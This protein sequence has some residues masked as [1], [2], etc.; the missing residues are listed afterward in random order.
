MSHNQIS[1]KFNLALH[2]L[3]ALPAMPEIAYRLLA[4]PLDT[5]AGEAQ[6]LS[7]IE[8]DPQ[9]SARI[10]GLANAPAMGSARRTS[11]IQDAA[12]LLGLQR[13]KSV[14]IGMA[15]LAQLA[16]QPATRNFDP[17]DLWSHSITVAIVMNLL[18]QAMPEQIRPDENQ[19]FLAGLL[20]DI[21]LMALHH[22]DYAACDELHHQVRLQP[23][24]S[25]YDIE[26]E[27]LGTTHGD[28]GAQ[29]LRHWHLPEELVGV[30]GRHHAAQGGDSANQLAKMVSLAERLLQDFG[31]AEHH[32]AAIS[33]A[34]WRELGIDPA[35]NDELAAMVNEVAI[36][37]I[38][39]PD[40]HTRPQ[41]TPSAAARRTPQQLVSASSYSHALAPAKTLFGWARRIWH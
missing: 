36:Q 15:T 24:R 40:T 6:M 37:V 22:I 16:D 18:A 4:L 25:I 31:V 35:R 10:I 20:H 1:G 28:I 21:G 26:L 12:M 41:G 5:E 30:A 34:E 3:D 11:S 38:Q 29:L 27:L 14:A 19:T 39:L 2:N 7:L 8:Q 9:L 17:H 13:L 32:H 33:D 23:R